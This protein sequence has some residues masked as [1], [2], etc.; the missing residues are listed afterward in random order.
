MRTHV[1][2]DSMDETWLGCLRN[3]KVKSKL[4]DRCISFA[5]IVINSRTECNKPFESNV[6]RS[7]KIP[8]G[9][10]K[11]V[12]IWTVREKKKKHACKIYSHVGR[13]KCL[14][15]ILRR[16]TTVGINRW[17]QSA[18]KLNVL[19]FFGILPSS[20]FKL[21]FFKAIPKIVSAVFWIF[22]H[23][24]KRLTLWGKI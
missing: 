9:Q 8:F 6:N 4:N 15:F 18:F 17:I 13:L 14:N 10:W 3:D 20:W 2:Y 5:W 21:A 19:D 24:L 22:I 11:Y 16:S 12:M 1:I 7:Y 23:F